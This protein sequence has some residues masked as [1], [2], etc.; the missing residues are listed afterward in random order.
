VCLQQNKHKVATCQKIHLGD[1]KSKTFVSRPG[2]RWPS[3]PA[4]NAHQSL[5]SAASSDLRL[6]PLGQPSLPGS[7]RWV[8]SNSSCIMVAFTVHNLCGFPRLCRW[9]KTGWEKG[10]RLSDESMEGADE[11]RSNPLAVHCG[12]R[13]AREQC[14]VDAALRPSRPI[15]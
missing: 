1:W 13:V 11:Q 7:T 6:V 8:T 5:L 10:V 4:T 9:R 15:R 3:S 12:R 14:P 2:S